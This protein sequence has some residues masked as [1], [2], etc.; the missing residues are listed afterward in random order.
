MRPK[1]E[2]LSPLELNVYKDFKT[3]LKQNTMGTQ[4]P[5]QAHAPHPPE[6]S[7]IPNAEEQQMAGSSGKGQMPRMGVIKLDEMMRALQEM[8][9]SSANIYHDSVKG[10]LKRFNS[11]LQEYD[12]SPKQFEKLIKDSFLRIC[13]LASGKPW[14][15]I[16]EKCSIYIELLL[17]IK[18]HYRFFP[19]KFTEYLFTDSSDEVRYHWE[20]HT[21][22]FKKN[23]IELSIFDNEF[24]KTLQKVVGCAP[25][26]RREI[27]TYISILVQRLWIEEKVISQNGFQNI[28]RQLEQISRTPIAHE[29]P[30][31]MKMLNELYKQQTV[32]T[33]DF[34]A[35]FLRVI[36]H[37][38]Y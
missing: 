7:P 1:K 37:R 11:D 12:K 8:T 36:F 34:K 26:I 19:N 9:E 27:L 20:L 18:A 21:V 30:H 4:P 16:S 2:G 3:V 22:F 38:N 13:F 35:L 32:S 17:I 31:F 10:L 23:L 6:P 5:Q 29:N 33:K 14:E 24:S 15:K 28:F 25:E